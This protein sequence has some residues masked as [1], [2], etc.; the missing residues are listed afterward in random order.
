MWGDSALIELDKETTET[1]VSES[2]IR[3]PSSVEAISETSD[4]N[5]APDEA[6]DRKLEDRPDKE[7]LDASQLKLQVDAT[8]KLQLR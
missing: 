8:R 3:S 4:A 2:D 5:E 6:L 1:V 7:V